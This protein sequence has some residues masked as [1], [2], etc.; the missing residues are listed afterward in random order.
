MSTVGST[1]STRLVF[2]DIDQR[3]AVGENILHMCFLN[4]TRV[5]YDIAKLIIKKFPPLVNDIYISDEYYGKKRSTL[6]DLDIN[7]GKL[8]SSFLP[9]VLMCLA[10]FFRFS[11]FFNM[12]GERVVIPWFGACLHVFFK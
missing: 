2:W 3:A 8:Q 7:L 12:L 1:K 9:S 4:A 10:K 6:Y 11:L 5:H